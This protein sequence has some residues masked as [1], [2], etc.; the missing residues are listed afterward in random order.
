MQAGFEVDWTS[1]SSALWSHSDDWSAAANGMHQHIIIA[2]ASTASEKRFNSAKLRSPRWCV[3]FP[4]NE[5]VT[6]TSRN[7]ALIIHLIPPNMLSHF[8]PPAG[9][10][11]GARKTFEMD[12]RRSE[13]EK[14]SW[15]LVTSTIY[16]IN[17]DVRAINHGVQG[18]STRRFTSG[19]V[20]ARS[21]T[22]GFDSTQLSMAKARKERNMVYKRRAIAHNP[23]KQWKDQLIFRCQKSLIFLRLRLAASRSE[24]SVW[25]TERVAVAKVANHGRRAGDERSGRYLSG[26]W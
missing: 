21:Q 19:N 6:E 10:G 8:S 12:C 13:R 7:A 22:N 18:W 5:Q 23:N 14:N 16:W 4:L 11:R 1:Q 15:H 9:V 17:I 20:A 26:E 2:S 24:W 3:V 25:W